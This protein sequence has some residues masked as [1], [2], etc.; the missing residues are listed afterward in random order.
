M[1]RRDAKVS[2]EGG[3]R[4]PAS[5]V[6]ELRLTLLELLLRFLLSGVYFLL[7]ALSG[8][9]GPSTEATFSF[10]LVNAHLL[11]VHILHRS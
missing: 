2:L 3:V 4:Q 10:V 9:R 1:E 8:L 11:L 5:G 7:G 6:V